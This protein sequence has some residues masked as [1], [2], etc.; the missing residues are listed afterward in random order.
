MTVVGTEDSHLPEGVEKK[1][2]ERKPE[3]FETHPLFLLWFCDG[4]TVDTI[5]CEKSPYGEKQRQEM[6]NHLTSALRGPGGKDSGP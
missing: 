6:A 1:D 4:D 2:V 3:K 5:R